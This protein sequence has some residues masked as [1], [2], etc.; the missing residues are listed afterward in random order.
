M[1]TVSPEFPDWV[2]KRP[3]GAGEMRA[4]SEGGVDHQSLCQRDKGRPY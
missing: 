1:I 4:I 2:E 3:V